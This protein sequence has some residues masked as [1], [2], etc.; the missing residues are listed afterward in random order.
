MEERR[1]LSKYAREIWP[2]RACQISHASGAERVETIA[3]CGDT[4][5]DVGRSE[6]EDK[7]SDFWEEIGWE[8][9]SGGSTENM[10]LIGVDKR[11]G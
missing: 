3:E 10:G 1:S 8:N 2:R 6:G 4:E 7:G 5:G 9:E 11:L